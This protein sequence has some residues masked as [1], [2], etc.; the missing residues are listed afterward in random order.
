MQVFFMI[1]ITTTGKRW[2]E[3]KM[4]KMKNKKTWKLQVQNVMFYFIW[5]HWC[6]GGG[7]GKIKHIGKNPQYPEQH[8]RGG[9]YR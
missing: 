8:E 9:N 5:T 2:H 1:K 7:G 4:K 3:E 6:L